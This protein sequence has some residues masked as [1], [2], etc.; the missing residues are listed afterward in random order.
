MDWYTIEFLYPESF[1]KFVQFMFPNVGLLSISTLEYFDI[2]KLYKF[3]DKEGI[4]LTIEMYNPHQWVFNISLGN[5]IVF[6]SFKESK[7]NREET[8][9]DGFHEC[10]K[11]LDKKLDTKYE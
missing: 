10:F 9:C 8:E 5:G 2:K 3:F 7:S 1:K 11:L 4:F 6:G